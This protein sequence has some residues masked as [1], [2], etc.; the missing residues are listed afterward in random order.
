[1]IDLEP[2][3]VYTGRYRDR[4]DAGGRMTMDAIQALATMLERLLDTAELNQGSLEP[5]TQD[6]LD[7]AEALL[8]ALAAMG[9]LPGR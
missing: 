9:V 6:T 5:E 8:E 3:S 7:E 1:M 2:H 4:P